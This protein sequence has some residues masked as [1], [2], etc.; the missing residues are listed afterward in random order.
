MDALAT[1]N[2]WRVAT[3][4]SIRLHEALRTKTCIFA[5]VRTH[6]S[7]VLQTLAR[8]VAGIYLEWLLLCCSRPETAATS[9]SSLPSI[10]ESEQL[11][12]MLEQALENESLPEDEAMEIMSKLSRGVNEL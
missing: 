10:M 9:P 2:L 12:E 7:N 11:F 1:T 5:P 8:L 4:E 6:H 3:P